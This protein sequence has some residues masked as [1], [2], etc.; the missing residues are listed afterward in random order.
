MLVEF[1]F[2]REYVSALRKEKKLRVDEVTK[3]SPDLEEVGEY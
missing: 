2:Q 3:A 1:L